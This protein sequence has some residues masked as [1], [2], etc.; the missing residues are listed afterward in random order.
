[1]VGLEIVGV[2]ALA[3]YIYK[4]ALSKPDDEPSKKKCG[5][6][7]VTKYIAQQ[8]R[9]AQTGF[10]CPTC[11]VGHISMEEL[12]LHFQSAH[13]HAWNCCPKK[14]ADN[15][16]PFSFQL[17]SELK[18]EVEV[19][20]ILAD[21]FLK[22]G[23]KWYDDLFEE[24]LG[25]NAA[26]FNDADNDL[27]EF[28]LSLSNDDWYA[29][30]FGEELNQLELG[31]E[32]D[33][34][35]SPT[36]VANRQWPSIAEIKQLQ[37]VES[38]KT[39]KLLAD[40][41][42]DMLKAVHSA[43]SPSPISNSSS[44]FI[45]HA[46]LN[47]IEEEIDAEDIAFEEVEKAAIVAEK[48]SDAAISDA[49]EEKGGSTMVHLMGSGKSV[50]TEKWFTSELAAKGCRN[51][52][53]HKATQTD[54]AKCFPLLEVPKQRV[55]LPR[56]MQPTKCKLLM[57]ATT[58]DMEAAK[59]SVDIFS[60]PSPPSKDKADGWKKVK[61]AI[62]SRPLNKAAKRVQKRPAQGAV[63]LPHYMQ[64]TKSKMSMINTT[65]DMEAKKNSL[66]IFSRRRSTTRR[67][68]Q[69][70]VS[71]RSVCHL[72]KKA[73]S[74]TREIAKCSSIID[75]ADQRTAAVSSDR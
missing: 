50:P 27:H 61:T 34:C 25:G 72:H 29:E 58:P 75:V 10:I 42:E 22:C 41:E 17:K 14:T 38:L 48:I 49:D 3:A 63:Q 66:D 45:S 64:P 39:Q 56:Y 40:L 19:K 62:V 18:A 32:C 15:R 13:D 70:R 20:A 53:E 5:H 46:T 1:M 47:P 7:Y 8:S 6:S 28:R 16:Q 43:A 4:V 54:A 57:A 33:K 21:P 60:S 74:S 65:A 31:G 44:L 2:G 52:C 30:Q 59:T 71:K 73:T 36:A 9:S 24:E 68:V 69:T 37:L 55:K 51:L 67:S 23:A 26:T 35:P 11:M 12:H